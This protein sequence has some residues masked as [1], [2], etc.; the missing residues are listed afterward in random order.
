MSLRDA[1]DYLDYLLSPRSL[2][3]HEEYESRIQVLKKLQYIDGENLVQ[4]KGRVAC[5][6]GNQNELMV[7]EMVLNNVLSEAT[8]EEVAALL[9]CMVFEMK[10]AE[11]PPLQHAGGL[12]EKIVT[13]KAIARHIGENQRECGMKE[14]VEQFV[15]QFK[16]GLAEVV[17]EWACGKE[18]FEIMKL[19][20]V[21]EG[22]IVRTIQRLDEMI[23]DVKDAARIIGDP[24][25]KRKMEE[26]S[27]CIK[28]DIVFAASLYTQ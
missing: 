12:K 6:M 27:E 19:T 24:A 28:R 8:P 4:L 7:T 11:E 2:R 18:F 21:Q 22:L 13:V 3:L 14:P 10:N 23:R 1:E 25:L 5:E 9:S 15:E 26:A 17:Y 16:F 20:D